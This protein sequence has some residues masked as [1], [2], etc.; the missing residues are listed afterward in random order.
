LYPG[1]R[2]VAIKID[3]M[4]MGNKQIQRVF[5]FMLQN[6]LVALIF[7]Q[8]TEV[9]GQAP[10]PGAHAHNDYEHE[11][12]L[13][14]ALDHGF[15]SVE[16]DVF[17]VEGQL[18]VYHDLPDSIDSTRTLEAL[19]LKPLAERVGE[20]GGHIYPGYDDFFYLMIDFKTK[21]DSTY[22]ALKPLLE[23]YE[24]ILSAVRDGE[25]ERTKPVKIFI[26]GSRPVKQILEETVTLAALD[27]RASDLG[28]E[29]PVSLMPV[30]SQNMLNYTLWRGRGVMRKA[31]QD[32]IKGLV[33]RTHAE[34]KKLRFWAAPDNKVAWEKLL[35]LGVDLINTDK[36]AELSAFLREKE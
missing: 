34:G 3:F 28:K 4:R 14:D 31:D 30:V 16:A 6:L 2:G 36:L 33:E 1:I 35:E 17:L 20:N 11:R 10:L 29:I 13:L 22:M 21:A 5:T 19:Y 27:G 8:A 12:P 25:E 23:K 32:R 15:T 9:S 7:F 24:G 18:Y 26:S